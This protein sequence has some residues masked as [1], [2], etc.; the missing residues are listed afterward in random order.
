MI[1]LSKLSHSTTVVILQ[2]R[3]TAVTTRHEDFLQQEILAVFFNSNTSKIWRMTN[4]TQTWV[5][6]YYLLQTK[7]VTN[8]RNFEHAWEAINLHIQR[9]RNNTIPLTSD[10]QDYQNCQ[11]YTLIRLS[12]I[13]SENFFLTVGGPKSYVPQGSQLTLAL[14]RSR[15]MPVESSSHWAVRFSDLRSGSASAFR[16]LLLADTRVIVG[17]LL[18]LVM[19]TAFSAFLSCF[20]FGRQKFCTES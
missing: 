14:F 1:F 20:F 13:P 17:D 5:A 18:A 6:P 3:R 12:V 7:Y 16:L 8:T 10:K 19:G 11:P 4:W 15:P 2:R 9:N